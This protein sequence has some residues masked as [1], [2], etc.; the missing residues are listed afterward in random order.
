MINREILNQTGKYNIV[1]KSPGVSDRSSMPIGN[2]DLAC[3]VWTTDSGINFYI[4]KS[5]SQTE[6][7]RNVKLGK[8][9]IETEP[10][11]FKNYDA[12][13]QELDIANGSIEINIKKDNRNFK[14]SILVD[15]SVNNIVIHGKFSRP[16]K[17]KVKY[18][19]WRTSKSKRRYPQWD[20]TESADRIE[21]LSD[22]MIFYHRNEQSIIPETAKLLAVND[23]MN[24]IP[25]TISGRIFGGVIKMINADDLSGGNVLVR[26]NT[27][28]AD[29]IVACSSNLNVPTEKW[30]Q[31]LN[32]QIEESFDFDTV[33]TRVNAFWN[34]YFSESWIFAEG[35]TKVHA[36]I[37]PEIQKLCKEPVDYECAGKSSI[38]KSYLL[39]KWMFAC[40]SKGQF[41]VLYNGM[42]FNLMPGNGTHFSVDSFAQNFSSQPLKEPDME[43]NPDER[44]WC[45]E[46][47]WQNIRHPY[48]S[49]LARGEFDRIKGLFDY[50]KNFS[51]INRIRAKVY[52][53]ASGQYNN[54]MTTTFGLQTP[55]IY[56]FD[57][58]G[59]PDG[60]TE[61]RAGA[62]VDISPGLELV[63]LMFEY[64]EYK[65]DL[66][67]L[68]KEILPL[69]YELLLFVETR[70]TKRDN[71]KIV[72][73]NLHCVE[74]YRGDVRDPITVVAGMIACLD[75]VEKFAEKIENN[76]LYLYFVNYKSK[77]PEIKTDSIA[78]E[79]I[80]LP[81]AKYPDKR[82]NVECPELY[83]VFPF[84]LYGVGK[85]NIKIAKNTFKRCMEISGCYRPFKIGETPSTPSYS[86]WQFIGTT[87][88]L[89]GMTRES[90]EILEAN[91]ALNNPGCRF[92]AMW[93][94]VY[95]AV[96]DTDHGANILNQFQWMLFQT[97]GKNIYL[98]PAWPKEWDVNFKFYADKET[99]VEVE[100]KDGIITKIEVVPA[101]R[102]ENIKV[103]FLEKKIYQFSK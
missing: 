44:S 59:K 99:T 22:R 55:E 100:Y 33:R 68:N 34:N 54:E 74:T 60:F 56:G 52:Y 27:S 102:M 53:N 20:I 3:S 37:N 7:D 79:I 90:K 94:P 98:F 83:A 88:A 49:M 13:I 32:N 31:M 58:E 41:P 69:L 16:L 78:N 45:I 18:I 67:F 40:C 77:V 39:T 48:H 70:F 80:L 87:S 81:A 30:K 73:E 26:E 57:R 97:D 10:N 5:D 71:G 84:K 62:A 85:S 65:E 24:Q 103:C 15:T 47:L 23:Y 29:I 4:S 95:D 89:L 76:N 17:V 28:D 12:F 11:I 86:G 75:F 64:Y 14:F 63:H 66:E 8:V 91:C 46:N 51:E 25:D 19:N 2:G 42:L 1:Y 38:T 93:G 36:D 61:N 35:D 21:T 96:P 50:Y 9:L 6:Y 82:E 43:I 101:S 92:P 72:L